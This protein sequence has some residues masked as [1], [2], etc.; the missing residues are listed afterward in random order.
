MISHRPCFCPFFFAGGGG[1]GGIKGKGTGTVDSSR[2]FSSSF[3]SLSSC[4][5][6]SKNVLN[7]KKMQLLMAYLG[8]SLVILVMF[9][10]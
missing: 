2:L 10:C 5:L 8:I 9:H 6:F 1:G 7:G 4:T 3:L